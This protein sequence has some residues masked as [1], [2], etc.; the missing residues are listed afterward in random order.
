[1]NESPASFPDQEP[2]APHP[3][4]SVLRFLTVSPR[5]TYVLLGITVGAYLLQILGGLIFRFDVMVA[6]WAKNNAAI[7]AGELWRLFTPIFPKS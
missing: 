5:V 1:M 7:R 2:A 4:T 6:L 3:G